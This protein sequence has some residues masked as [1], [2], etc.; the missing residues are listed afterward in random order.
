MLGNFGVFS[1]MRSWKPTVFLTTCISAT[2]F[3]IWTF[4]AFLYISK[5]TRTNFLKIPSHNLHNVYN[6]LFRLF[7]G[8]RSDPDKSLSATCLLYSD[9]VGGEPSPTWLRPYQEE[10]EEEAVKR[11]KKEWEI[12][13]HN[14]FFQLLYFIV[15]LFFFYPLICP[16]PRP[17]TF[18]YKLKIYKIWGFWILQY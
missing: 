11:A 7:R 15:F 18:S 3:R 13:V 1:F 6:N 12:F 16:H 17:T 9:V 8:D 14:L 10:D 4:S 5:T 2:S